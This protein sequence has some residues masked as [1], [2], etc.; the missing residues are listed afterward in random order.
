MNKFTNENNIDLD[1]N[2]IVHSDLISS[3]NN[4][5]SGMCKDDTL[6]QYNHEYTLC[7][8]SKEKILM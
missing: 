4:R 1:L 3:S 7:T 5:V 6:M 8:F 2:F